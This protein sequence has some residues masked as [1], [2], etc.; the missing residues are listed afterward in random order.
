LRPSREKVG[1]SNLKHKLE[2]VAH[3]WGSPLLWK[4]RS[5]RQKREILSDKQT[6]SK[7]IGSRG[8][9]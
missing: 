6:K 8:R 9:G 1:R 5:S 3:T 4:P 7:R 2:V